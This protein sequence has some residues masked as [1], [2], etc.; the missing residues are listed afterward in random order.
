M[1]KLNGSGFR[2][3]H[4]P[5][6]IVA[7]LL[8]GT[9]AA[10]NAVIDWDAIASTSIITNGSTAANITGTAPGATTAG[11]AG[12]YLAFVHLAMYNAIEAIEGKYQ[13]YFFSLNAPKDASKDAAA[14]TAAH[15]VLVSYFPDQTALLDSQFA[16]SM[17]AIQDGREKMDGISVGESAAATL[18]SM[19][20]NDGRGANVPYSYPGSPEPGV[21]V[22]TPPAFLQPLTPWVGQMKPLT[23]TEPSE[24]LPPGPPDLG[25]KEWA[26]DYNET[27]SLG[28]ATSSLRTPEQTEVGLFWTE[29]TA[30]LYSR[31]FRQLATEKHL[32]LASS[33]RL[34]AMLWT[35][36]T[37]A[38]IGC[39]NAKYAFSFWRP[40]TAIQN[41][42]IDSNPDTLPD[43]SWTP[44][45]T[46]PNHPE[47]PAAHGCVSGAAAST[48]TRFFDQETPLNFAVSSI[49]TNTSH[50]FATPRDLER[51]VFNARIYAGFHYRH[52]LRDGFHLGH[53]VVQ[54]ML[55]S[56]FNARPARLAVD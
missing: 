17:A 4:C 15:R 7:I 37:D 27:K 23:M 55:K 31:T 16:Q 24:F 22:P 10:Q 39:M 33:A 6:V 5:I 28:S 56:F 34:F 48:L 52:S 32:D 46:T 21:W 41:G 42:D 43:P 20:V 26:R 45:G 53:Q 47:Y 18:I 38:F 11:G 51:E 13:P 54:Q 9:A 14:I 36:Y 50:S 1:P 25:S 12:I 30:Q 44:L 49:V 2:V 29:H 3:S 40:V 35:G 19:R 8:V